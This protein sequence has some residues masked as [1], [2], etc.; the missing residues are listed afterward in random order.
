M[1]H[2]LSQLKALPGRSEYR[3]VSK[4]SLNLPEQKFTLVKVE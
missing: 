2:S 1:G 3:D 4:S